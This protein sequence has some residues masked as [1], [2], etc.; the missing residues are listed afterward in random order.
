MSASIRKLPRDKLVSCISKVSRDKLEEMYYDLLFDFKNLEE[1][2]IELIEEIKQ[3]E[4]I[5]ND[6]YAKEDTEENTE[7]EEE[8]GESE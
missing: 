6:I 4:D 7:E 1:E 2:K 5:L 3:L 8:T